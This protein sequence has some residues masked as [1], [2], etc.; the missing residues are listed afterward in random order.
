MWQRYPFKLVLH[1]PLV[2]DVRHP[3]GLDFDQQRKVVML[4]DDKGMS[5]AA[6]VDPERGGVV[7]LQGHPTCVDVAKRSYQKFFKRGASKPKYDY[8]KCGRKRWKF[9]PQVEAFLLRTLRTVRKTGICTSK[10]L[11][12]LLAK[13]KGLAVD[14]STIRKFLKKK[15][16]RWVSRA[17]KRKYSGPEME[18][19]RAFVKRVLRMTRA[20]LRK[21]LGLSLDGVVLAMPPAGDVAR[22]NHCMSAETHMWRKPS[23]A[24]LPELAGDDPYSGQ[25]PLARAVPM[26]GG[27]S[28]GGCGHVL[29]HCRKKCSVDEW[30]GAVTDGT[31]GTLLRRLNPQIKDRPWRVLCDGE[32]FLHSTAA[33][34]VY[35]RH[36][37]SVWKIPPR[38][39]DLNP[40]E[41]FWSWLRRELRRRDLEDYRQ[42]KPC[43]TKV[44]YIARVKEVLRTRKAHNVAARIAAGFRKTCKEVDRKEGAAARS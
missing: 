25:V 24:A 2:T 30:V 41:K 34:T 14:D 4:R 32:A 21:E 33:H 9:T 12:C 23:E 16:Y 26:W 5:W 20:Q 31:L 1:M 10:T 18:V 22:W 40:V 42:K 19:R 39:P 27:I 8:S 35:W 36:S 6:I 44:Q 28:E 13:E 15:G 38:S 3:R 43:L 29:F 11:Q 17:Q 7:N 37:I